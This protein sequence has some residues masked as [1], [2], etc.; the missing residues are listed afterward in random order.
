MQIAKLGQR[1]SWRVTWPT[2]KILALPPWN[3]WN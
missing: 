2:F 3:F 1:E